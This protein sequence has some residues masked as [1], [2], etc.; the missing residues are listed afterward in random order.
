[1]D[2][3]ITGYHRDEHHDWVAELECL[4][5]RHVRHSPPFTNREWVET[6]AGRQS[7][8]GMALDCV[9]CDRLEMPDDL[10]PYKRTPEF[11]ES[12]IPKGLLKAHSTK[13]GAW[14]RIRVLEGV[15]I[16]E[17]AFPVPRRFEIMK[18]EDGVIAPEVMHSV[19]APGKVRF[20]VEFYT[21]SEPRSTSR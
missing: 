21:R 18:D 1:M 12:T 6:E 15:L 19:T 4:H 16:Y 9:R 5:G 2:R 20:F 13:A 17:V 3:R 7:K 10:V 8:L 11:S 14:G